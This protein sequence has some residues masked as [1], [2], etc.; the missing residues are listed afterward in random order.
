MVEL[1]EEHIDVLKELSNLIGNHHSDVVINGDIIIEDS[2]SST[3]TTKK[4]TQ[5]L[6]NTPG[7]NSWKNKV[8]QRDKVCQCCGTDKHLEVHH[9]MPLSVYPSLGTDIHNGMVLCQTCHRDYH[10]QWKDSEGAAT[11]TKFLRENGRFL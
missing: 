3:T 4:N 1:N 7:A 6:R 2:G 9:V 10:Q 11:L 8:K 5:K